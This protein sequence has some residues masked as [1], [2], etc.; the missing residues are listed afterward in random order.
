M[1]PALVEGNEK[2]GVAH[3]LQQRGPFLVASLGDIGGAALADLVPG[4][5][6][7]P[8]PLGQGLEAITVFLEQG[9][10]RPVLQAADCGNDQPHQQRSG[11]AGPDA[12]RP[13][14]DRSASA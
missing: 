13:P 6:G 5:R 3:Q 10:L 12:P 1:F 7:E 14:T 2:F 9:A 4:D 11:G 8:Q